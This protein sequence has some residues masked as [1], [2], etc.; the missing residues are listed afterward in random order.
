MMYIYILTISS[1]AGWSLDFFEDRTA[2]GILWPRFES[3]KIPSPVITDD[4]PIITDLVVT[5][6]GIADPVIT[7]PVITDPVITDH[8]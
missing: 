6:P 5:D 8:H 4:G 3:S 7:D 2:P 1:C